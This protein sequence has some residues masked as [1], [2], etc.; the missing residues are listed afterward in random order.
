MASKAEDVISGDEARAS[1]T[2][3][4]AA[5]LVACSRLVWGA[6]TLAVLVWPRY[7][8]RRD[9]PISAPV[10]RKQTPIILRDKTIQLYQTR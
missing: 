4:G 9:V 2:A 1:E 3:L 5:G 8:E 7:A 10:A 6:Q